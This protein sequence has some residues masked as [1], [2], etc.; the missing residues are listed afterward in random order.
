M[1]KHSVTAINGHS[2]RQSVLAQVHSASE[3]GIVMCEGVPALRKPQGAE[4]DPWS[5]QPSRGWL[6]RLGQSQ[7]HWQPPAQMQRKPLG[8]TATRAWHDSWSG[9][10]P[11]EGGN[12]A[13]FFSSGN[14]KKQPSTE[15]KMVPTHS[16]FQAEAE[17]KTEGPQPSQAD[18]S[19]KRPPKDW[20]SCQPFNFRELHNLEV[21][22]GPE[23][24][25]VQLCPSG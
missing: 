15:I 1:F 4:K 24:K 19:P 8:S 2:R 25:R 20:K 23:G 12:Q 3:Q 22:P 7:E 6:T 17:I 18:I 21:L 14:N 9:R 11:R 13:N 16:N 5:L 10:L